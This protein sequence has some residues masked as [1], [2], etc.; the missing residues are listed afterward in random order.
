MYL[1]MMF[2]S[3]FCQCSHSMLG[4]QW[5]GI[6]DARAIVLPA[7]S[8]DVS[9]GND[10]ASVDEVSERC[11]S[12]VVDFLYHIWPPI[13]FLSAKEPNLNNVLSFVSGMSSFFCLYLCMRYW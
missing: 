11:G 10:N 1:A 7:L 8:V 2:L 3:R 12:N 5:Q 9:V 6:N 13:P 4:W